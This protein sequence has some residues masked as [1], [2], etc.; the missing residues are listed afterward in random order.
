MYIHTYIHDTTTIIQNA[1]FVTM[2]MNVAADINIPFVTISTF[3]LSM[4]RDTGGRQRH[5]RLDGNRMKW[6]DSAWCVHAR[7]RG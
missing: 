5:Y 2:E 1:P 4:G 3:L 7:A 6:M